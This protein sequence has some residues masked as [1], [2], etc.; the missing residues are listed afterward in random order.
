MNK[1]EYQ[2]SCLSEECGETV[3]AIGKALRFGLDHVW[4]EKGETNRREIEREV[5]QILCVFKELGFT[6]HEEDVLLKQKKLDKFMALSVELG[7]L[8]E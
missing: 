6:L 4:P 3:Q 2:L 8:K 1:T 7:T 5:A